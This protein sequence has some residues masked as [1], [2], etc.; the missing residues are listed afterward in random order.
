[1]K[2][3]VQRQ[4]QCTIRKPWEKPSGIPKL[5]YQPTRKC[6]SSIKQK[7]IFEYAHCTIQ[8]MSRNIQDMQFDCTNIKFGSEE[9]RAKKRVHIH[10]S[11][12]V[13]LRA[14]TFFFKIGESKRR[15]GIP[16][17]FLFQ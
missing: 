3:L 2:V 14:Q 7:D 16:I 1:M 8:T 9:R 12:F 13:Q 5:F 17:F 4:G 15:V 6:F 10:F 11:I